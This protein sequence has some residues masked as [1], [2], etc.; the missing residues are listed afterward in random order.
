MVKNLSILGS[1][2]SIGTQTID[3]A[4]SLGIN[5]TAISANRNIK[6]LEDQARE[7]S[8]KLVAV[9]DESAAKELK[10]ALSDIQYL[11]TMIYNYTSQR[12]LPF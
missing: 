4:R 10:I 1:T 8:P 9:A 7:F 3:V 5:I 11:S 6:L 2:G 12:H